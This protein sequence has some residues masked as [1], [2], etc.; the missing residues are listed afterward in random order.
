MRFLIAL[1]I[2]LALGSATVLAQDEPADEPP[3]DNAPDIAA[4]VQVAV[5]GT[6]S[7][8]LTALPT[9]AP[10]ATPTPPAMNPIGLTGRGRLN[11]PPFRL[12]G[13]NYSV[14]WTAS[15][16]GTVGCF[17]S[18][19]MRAVDGSPGAETVGSGSVERGKSRTGATQMYNVKPNTYYLAISSSCDWSVTIATQH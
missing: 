16:S 3:A 14:E 10:T 8:W 15:D 6:V 1:A 12:D 7:A 4:T 18:G 13:G 2:L 5:A 19:D 11:T 17:H 9:P